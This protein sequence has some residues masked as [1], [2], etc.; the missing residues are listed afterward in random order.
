MLFGPE[1]GNVFAAADHPDRCYGFDFY[2]NAYNWE[3]RR[4][5]DTAVRKT[6]RTI[7]RILKMDVPDNDIVL[8]VI[9]PAAWVY[10]DIH[11]RTPNRSTAVCEL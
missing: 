10:T 6:V 7:C 2:P 9:L 3:L 8:F 4:K 11:L 5:A 1:M